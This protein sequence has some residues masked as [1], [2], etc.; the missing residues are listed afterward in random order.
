M[1]I[2]VVSHDDL[3]V[4]CGGCGVD[5]VGVVWRFRVVCIVLVFFIWI[6]R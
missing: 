2:Y 5:C 3:C 1:M 6:Q 4:F